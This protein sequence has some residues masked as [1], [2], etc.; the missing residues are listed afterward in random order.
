MRPHS[1]H[2]MPPETSFLFKKI[3]ENL[4]A[5]P[6]LNKRWTLITTTNPAVAL[7]M[8][9]RPTSPYIRVLIT[10]PT[11]NAFGLAEISLEVGRDTFKI[12]QEYFEAYP[13]FGYEVPFKKDF[14][15]LRIAPIDPH[16]TG[17]D[18]WQDGGYIYYSAQ[19]INP[20]REDMFESI[21]PWYV[22]CFESIF[23][24]LDVVRE[25]DRN[26]STDN[27]SPS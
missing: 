13:D 8:C 23:H 4:K 3:N 15:G 19:I 11:S 1:H 17:P 5:R 26:R 9:M 16:A 14:G 6:H 10:S 2:Y 18:S 20:F 12:T 27:N 21:A 7:I 22:D 25:W 24:L